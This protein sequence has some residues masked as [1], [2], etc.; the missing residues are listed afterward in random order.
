VCKQETLSADLS[1]TRINNKKGTFMNKT[2]TRAFAFISTAAL[3]LSASTLHASTVKSEKFQIPFDFQVQ[4]QKTLPAGEYQVQQATGSEV[5]ILVNTR[6]G[7][8]VELLRPTSTHEEGKTRL[9]FES[10]ENG[11]SLKQIS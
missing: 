11:H 3:L 5:A 8:R 7:E 4:K 9:V 6:T 1:K 2:A 10:T